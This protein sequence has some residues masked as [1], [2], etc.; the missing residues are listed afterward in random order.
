MVCSGL[1]LAIRLSPVTP[2]VTQT[3]PDTLNTAP[4]V[5]TPQVDMGGFFA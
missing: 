4:H 5:A 1:D 3:G 2:P